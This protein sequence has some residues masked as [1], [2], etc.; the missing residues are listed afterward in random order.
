MFRL[1]QFMREIESPTPVR[2]ARPSGPVVIWNLIRRCNLN[3]KHCYALSADVDFAGELSGAE[4]RTVRVTSVPAWPRGH[5]LGPGASALRHF[6][7]EPRRPVVVG[8]PRR[9]K[10]VLK[11]SGAPGLLAASASEESVNKRAERLVPQRPRV[12]WP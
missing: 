4:A 3:C 10:K 5:P 1:S 7:S 2:P 8:P 9:A 11:L 6:L 12:Q